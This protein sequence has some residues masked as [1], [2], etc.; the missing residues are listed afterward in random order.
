[1]YKFAVCSIFIWSQ[2]ESQTI[3]SNGSVVDFGWTKPSSVYP[4]CCGFHPTWSIDEFDVDVTPMMSPFPLTLVLSQTHLFLLICAPV[5]MHVIAWETLALKVIEM[6]IYVLPRR[7]S[8][9]R[10]TCSSIS[11]ILCNRT[12]STLRLRPRGEMLLTSAQS[13]HPK[14]S[15]EHFWQWHQ[16]REDADN[17]ARTSL[18][19]YHS[20]PFHSTIF[21]SLGHFILTERGWHL[22]RRQPS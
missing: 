21:V 15:Y 12:W 6:T 10:W 17:A 1:M 14:K 5:C 8:W 4:I 13:A 22:R 9:T 7:F 20:T 18:D 19:A 3:E 2:L 11:P 16:V